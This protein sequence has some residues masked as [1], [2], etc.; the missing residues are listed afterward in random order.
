MQKFIERMKIERADLAGKI[1]RA[2]AAIENPPFGADKESIDLLS[3]Q[4]K[5]MEQ[6]LYWLDE[7]IKKETGK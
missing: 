3:N 2:K 7:R 5:A 1:K 4:V 6:Y